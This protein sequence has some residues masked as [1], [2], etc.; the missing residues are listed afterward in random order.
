MTPRLVLPVLAVLIAVPSAG[1]QNTVRQEERMR[2]QACI[3]QSG[4]DAAGALEEAQTWRIEGGGWPAEICEAHAFIGLGDFEMAASILEELAGTPQPGMVDAERVEFLTLAGETRARNGDV[5]AALDD[6]AAALEIDPYS[7]LTLSGR[8]RLH[9]AEENWGGLERD[10]QHLIDLVPESAEGW[11]LRGVYHLN[12]G[13]HDAAWTDMQA[14]RERAPERVEIL[15]LRG[16]INEAR[17]L[18]STD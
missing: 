13:D 4:D 18:A 6:Y 8:G 16:Q 5:E 10:A 12:T 9:L 14:A 17:R 1:A 15:V 11:Y 7:I 3:A 2:Y